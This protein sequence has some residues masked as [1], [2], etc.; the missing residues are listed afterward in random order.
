MLMATVSDAGPML[1]QRSVS[2][3]RI[4]YKL[5]VTRTLSQRW[6]SIG[7]PFATLAQH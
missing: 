2:L 6:F 5:L 7:P 4:G 1:S 3:Y